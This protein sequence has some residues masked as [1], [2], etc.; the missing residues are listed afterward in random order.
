MSA[1]PSFVTA[2]TAPAESAACEPFKISSSLPARTG[3]APRDLA[4]TAVTIVPGAFPNGWFFGLDPQLPDVLA[5]WGAGHPAFVGLLGPDGGSTFTVPAVPP[6]VPLQAVALDL[7]PTL[8]WWQPSA[9][10]SLVTR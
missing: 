8:R 6:G 4:F 10:V 9:P 7:D 5:Q 3:A 2:V 1:A